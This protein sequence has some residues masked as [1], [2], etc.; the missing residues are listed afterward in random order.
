MKK[1]I[2]A[3]LSAVT[4]VAGV[5]AQ[6]LNNGDWESTLNQPW[7][8]Q[9]GD[10]QADLIGWFSSAKDGPFNGA[11]V[12]P[13]SGYGSGAVGAL[14]A[15][16]L[17]NY[18]Q[19]QIGGIHAGMT[20][21]F[22]VNYDGGIRYHGT[23]PADARDI[24]LRVSLWDV[25]AD[26]ELAGTDVVTAYTNTATSLEARTHV[27][28]YDNT[29]LDDHLVALRFEN[30]TINTNTAAFSGSAVLFDNI[31]LLGPE[32]VGVAPE[33]VQDPFSAADGVIEEAYSGTIAG[34]AT[35]DDG[36]ELT[37]SKV[38]GPAWLDVASDGILSGSPVVGGTNVFIV[39]VTDGLYF[40]T[41]DLEIYVGGAVLLNGDWESTLNLNWVSSNSGDTQADLSGWFS[42]LKETDTGGAYIEPISGYGEGVVGALKSESDNYFQ[43]TLN[44]IDAGMG[45]IT[46]NYDGG[47][48]YHGSY[49]TDPRNITLR[50]SLWDATTAVELVG[51]NVV[52]AFSD[53]ETSLHTRSHVL[54]YDAAGLDGHDLAL[55]FENITFGEGDSPANIAHSTALIDNISVI[56]REILP[57]TL[58]ISNSS[59][60]NVEVSWDGID[61]STYVVMTNGNLVTPDWQEFMSTNVSS[62]GRVNIPVPAD[63][64]Q[65]F[66]QVITE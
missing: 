53:T 57:V 43:Q 64:D 38:D 54:T 55:R 2:L 20:N 11:Y 46:V 58:S 5:H 62:S 23:Y 3:I 48:R 52:T 63:E 29:G 51:T 30:T 15:T 50:V 18:F 27:L 49:V 56:A 16:K 32:P 13:I 44:E 8:S 25:T 4:L 59:P 9:T 42:S 1:A 6:L 35:D 7:I 14:K 26:V 66:Y 47:I 45:Q 39:G 61:A 34:S 12:E 36:D 22:T 33:F 40:S 60:G 37:Y 21:S 65:V 24:T 10:T 41:A 19:Q 17:D 31:V 28:A